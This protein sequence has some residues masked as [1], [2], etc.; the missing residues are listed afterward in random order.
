[1]SVNT[2]GTIGIL[3]DYSAR[4]FAA[5]GKA[6]QCATP[7]VSHRASQ[8]LMGKEAQGMIKA[9]ASHPAD[10][11]STADACVLRFRPHRLVS[12][13]LVGDKLIMYRTDGL[14]WP[15]A[16]EFER[17]EGAWTAGAQTAAPIRIPGPAKELPSRLRGIG[18][19]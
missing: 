16:A 17:G 11:T 15:E 8:R 2:D 18:R 5:K 14:E 12:L 9:N 7:D 19:F 3:H 6:W 1:V 10:V 4:F 13:K